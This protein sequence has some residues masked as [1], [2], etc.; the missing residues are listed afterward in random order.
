MA[1]FLQN[2]LNQVEPPTS[3]D[4][5]LWDIWLSQHYLPTVTVSIEIGLFTLLGK[6]HGLTAVEISSKLNIGPR[7]TDALLAVLSALKLVT[8]N[9]GKFQLTDSARTYCIPE[10]LFFWGPVLFGASLNEYHKRLLNVLQNNDASWSGGALKEWEMGELSEERARKLTDLMNAHSFA[11]SLGVARN[12]GW[13]QTKR[14]LDVAGGS[15]CF[16]ISLAQKHHHFEK[17]TVAELPVVCKVA[18]EFIQ[19][20][21][22][23]D[24]VDTF[25]F[26]MF[27]DEWP[28]NYDT[29]FFSNVFHDW[30]LETCEML[31]KR[32]FDVL[33]SGGKILLH[34]IL[35]RE[36]KDGELTAACF[37]VHML[38]HNKGK[39]FTGEELRQ[40]L[41]KTGFTNISTTHTYGYYSI[42]TGIKP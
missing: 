41:E 12:Y 23:Q 32:S 36:Q 40:L 14:F 21:Q 31:A 25:A 24:K 1:F 7:S 27:T 8:K 42:V 2:Q 18:Q 9:L 20:F 5:I 26:N 16:T 28:K 34:E 6:E 39:Q 22:V 29:H 35:L 13:K 37:S 17:L 15:G 3:P 10:S 4:S 19:K 38:I 33:P 30:S 11:A